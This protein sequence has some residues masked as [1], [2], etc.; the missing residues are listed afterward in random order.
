MFSSGPHQLRSFCDSLGLHLSESIKTKN[1]KGEFVKLGS[2]LT[3]PGSDPPS[4]SFALVQEGQKLVLG[5]QIAKAPIIESIE[6]WTSVA[7]FIHE[8]IS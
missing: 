5:Q 8:R 3:P 4:M 6:D 2:L 1:H 7:A